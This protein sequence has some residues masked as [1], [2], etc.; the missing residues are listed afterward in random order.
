[1]LME[2]T[3]R[4][5][6]ISRL[7]LGGGGPFDHTSSSQLPIFHNI[8]SIMNEKLVNFGKKLAS[9]GKKLDMISNKY[10]DTVNRLIV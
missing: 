9:F 10:L 3:Q 7:S 1:M 8:A 5:G 2:A 4:V 6:R